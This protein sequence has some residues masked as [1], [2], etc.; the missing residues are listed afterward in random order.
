MWCVQ[1]GCKA[2]QSIRVS[3]DCLSGFLCASLV[4]RVR[5]DAETRGFSRILAGTTLLYGSILLFLRHRRSRRCLL[6]LAFVE[7]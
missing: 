4:V 6:F 7:T 5:V 3:R 1:N 2:N